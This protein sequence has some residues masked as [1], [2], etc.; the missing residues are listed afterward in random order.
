MSKMKVL[1]VDDHPIVRLGLC[2]LLNAQTDLTV[3]GQAESGR[4]ALEKARRLHPDVIVLDLSM[5][6]LN[7]IEV[8]R[9]LKREAP[10]IGLVILS[11]H[12]KEVYV[13][14]AL[15]AGATAYVLKG[16]E[17]GQILGAIHAASR[18]EYFLCSR[19]NKGVIDAFLK[20]SRGNGDVEPYELLSAR[21]QQV[22][23]LL[24]EGHSVNRIAG[25]LCLSPKTVEKH[26]SN[27]LRKLHCSDLLS[28][29]K[30]AVKVGVI[31]PDAW[32]N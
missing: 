21:E 18:G 10:Q 26:R 8:A 24:V 30:Y 13:L 28:L 12:D 20:R 31:D 15:E 29:I 16:A 6:D 22:F 19:I 32:K 27:T 9:Q 25:I 7:G 5:P 2:D 14:Q 4:E 3:V 11:M 17:S 23:R 1:V